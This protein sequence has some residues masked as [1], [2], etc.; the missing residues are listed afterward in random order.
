MR[1]E[2][3][4]GR[5]R[6]RRGD[7]ADALDKGHTVI[8]IVTETTGAWS[9][10]LESTLRALAAAAATADGTDTTV[11]GRSRASPRSFY[12][13]HAAAVSNAIV[14]ADST[15]DGEPVRPP[16]VAVPARVTKNVTQ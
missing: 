16:A 14:A 6:A 5:V 9:R 3:G 8:L 11:Y 15:H 7:Y 13:H 2:T 12:G 4:V 10:A 1:R